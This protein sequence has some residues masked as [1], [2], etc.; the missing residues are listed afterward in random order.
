MI[1]EKNIDYFYRLLQKV[2][3]VKIERKVAVSPG[4]RSIYGDSKLL[5]DY[6]K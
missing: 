6:T 5:D 3:A 4:R 2:T 1:L